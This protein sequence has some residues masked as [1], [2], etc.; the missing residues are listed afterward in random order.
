MLKTRSCLAAFILFLINDAGAAAQGESSADESCF[1]GSSDTGRP[2]QFVLLGKSMMP[3]PK[4][5]ISACTLA[6][7]D[8][9]ASSSLREKA[10]YWR[11]NYNEQLGNYGLAISDL[12]HA[13]SLNRSLAYAYKDRGE[14]YLKLG[15]YREAI[16][17][18]DQ[19]IEWRPNDAGAYNAR[20]WAR[21]TI[22]QETEAA[23]VDCNK[24]VELSPNAAPILDSRGLVRFRMGNYWLAIADCSAAL[25]IDPKQAS[26]LYVRGLARL[27]TADI[28]GGNVDIEAAKVLDPT[29][30]ETYARYGVR[31]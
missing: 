21:A 14:A 22:G 8:P 28:A 19:F 31:P 11:G 26:S 10:Y 17:D 29:I 16:E 23:L 6:I 25:D 24:A 4:Q 9:G 15:K 7:L 18:F 27:K 3:A 20:C 12:S 1:A 2:L 30:A 13:L 5:V